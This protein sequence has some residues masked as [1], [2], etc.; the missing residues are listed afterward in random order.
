MES[1]IPKYFK[2][3][4]QQMLKVS[5]KLVCQSPGGAQTTNLHSPPHPALPLLPL[6]SPPKTSK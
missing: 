1:I 2:K 4:V 3:G 5:L 6:L